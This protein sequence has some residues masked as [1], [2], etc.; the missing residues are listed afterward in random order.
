MT[1]GTVEAPRATAPL[2]HSRAPGGGRV[3]SNV[4]AI[5]CMSSMRK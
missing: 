5:D 4:D 1:E 2:T 3:R